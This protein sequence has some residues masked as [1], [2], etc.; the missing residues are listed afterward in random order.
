MYKNLLLTCLIFF[1]HRL[2]FFYVQ[3]LFLELSLSCPHLF[4]S[5][6]LSLIPRSIYL[7]IS[8][9]PMKKS[10]LGN[11]VSILFNE[12]HFLEILLMSKLKTKIKKRFFYI[13]HENHVII[14]FPLMNSCFIWRIRNKYHF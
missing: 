3:C 12:Q 1:T 4:C 10:W 13:R 8:L 14:N 9:C 11:I 7:F 6:S 2:L 5:F